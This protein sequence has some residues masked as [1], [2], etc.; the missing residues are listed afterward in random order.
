MLFTTCI[1]RRSRVSPV[2]KKITSVDSQLTMTTAMTVNL[3]MVGRRG[4]RT[5]KSMCCERVQPAGKAATE[6]MT[7]QV[8]MIVVVVV[9]AG[10]LGLRVDPPISGGN[11]SADKI[12]AL[13]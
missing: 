2:R 11:L 5:L 1:R 12:G 7:N 9:S 6:T 8:T 4:R 10:A 13:P 3:T